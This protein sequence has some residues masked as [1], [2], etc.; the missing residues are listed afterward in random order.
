MKT[1][2]NDIYGSLLDYCVTLVEAPGAY[3]EFPGTA[4]DL[5][6]ETLFK[7]NYWLKKSAS[8]QQKDDDEGKS[9]CPISNQRTSLAKLEVK[10]K[11]IAIDRITYNLVRQM[12]TAKDYDVWEFIVNYHYEILL[13]SCKYIVKDLQNYP[14][15]AY[16]MTNATFIKAFLFLRKKWNGF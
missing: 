6:Q 14:G 3:K 10:A 5:A 15:D 4:E 9:T 2:Q 8:Q 1:N 16:D 7:A 13:N 12:I 11:Y